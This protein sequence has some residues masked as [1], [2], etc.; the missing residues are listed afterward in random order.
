[1]M[2]GSHFEVDSSKSATVNATS[3]RKQHLI[4]NGEELAHNTKQ[5]GGMPL[6]DEMD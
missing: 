5:N 1:M 3:F 6:N 4:N 2:N